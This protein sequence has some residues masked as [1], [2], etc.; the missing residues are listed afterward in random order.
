MKRRRIKGFNKRA[1][2]SVRQT[3]YMDQ[4][5]QASYFKSRKRTCQKRGMFNTEEEAIV[6]AEDYNRRILFANMN[7]YH[8]PRH[9]CWHIGHWDKNGQAW[10][11]NPPRV[12]IQ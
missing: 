4:E 6:A 2:P 11:P 10:T 5:E 9:Q 3:M 8:C 12:R 1:S 7:A